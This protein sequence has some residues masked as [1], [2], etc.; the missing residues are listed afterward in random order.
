[1]KKIILLLTFLFIVAISCNHPGADPEANLIPEKSGSSPGYTIISEE[2][3]A[4]YESDPEYTIYFY[5][6]NTD[7]EIFYTISPVPYVLTEPEEKSY[8]CVRRAWEMWCN[9]AGGW[10][11]V[12]VYAC[13]EWKL[14]ID[15]VTYKYF[16]SPRPATEG[17]PTDY[18]GHMYFSQF[19]NLKSLET[20]ID[21]I[22]GEPV[23]SVYPVP[24]EVLE[25][26]FQPEPGRPYRCVEWTWKLVWC[27]TSLTGYC[28]KKF[29]TKTQYY[30]T[31]PCYNCP[32]A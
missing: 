15:A 14:V 28:F 23:Y 1:M 16:N 3:K 18:A 20:G 12:P 9:N 4:D 22:T 10:V 11:C 29:C 25:I 7:D 24:E 19:S 27:D 17:F 30:N 5:G 26:I 21:K 2:I 32:P 8:T 13:Q 31:P 6:E